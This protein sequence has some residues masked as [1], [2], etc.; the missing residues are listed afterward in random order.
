MYRSPDNFDILH[1]VRPSNDPSTD[2]VRL[3]IAA[4]HYLDKLGLSSAQRN[5]VESQVI[6][7][8]HAQAGRINGISPTWFALMQTAIGALAEDGDELNARLATASPAA[9]AQNHPARW[10]EQQQSPAIL[11][12]SMASK[13]F[14]RKIRE[15]LEEECMP[16][17]A[18]RTPSSMRNL[19]RR[20]IGQKNVQ[21]IP[22]YSKRWSF[23]HT[24][25]PSQQSHKT[26]EISQN[27]WE[28]RRPVRLS[29]RDSSLV[30]SISTGGFS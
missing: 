3:P 9:R 25:F 17:W 1:P 28:L 20:P 12:S 21:R 26:Y 19:G 30:K 15:Y 22:Q 8:L 18:F 7:G 23:S 27:Y 14:V 16:V 13:R 4:T 2:T 10:F 29:R 24:Y 11:R 5:W 6:T